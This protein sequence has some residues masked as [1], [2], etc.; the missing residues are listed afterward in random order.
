MPTDTIYWDDYPNGCGRV[1]NS[2][3]HA[4]GY[5]AS[6]NSTSGNS[7]GQDAESIGQYKTSLNYV[8]Y[9]SF[10]TFDLSSYTSGAYTVSA[11]KL[12][13]DGRSGFDSSDTDFDMWWCLGQDWGTLTGTDWND[14]SGWVSS[15][16]Y[17]PT[18]YTDTW[19]S[20]SYSNNDNEFTLNTAGKAYVEAQMEA[21]S[22]VYFVGLSH[23]DIIASQPTGAEVISFDE[24]TTLHRLQITYTDDS[25]YGNSVIGVSNPASV[26]GVAGANILNVM[27]V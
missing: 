7:G 27:G 11:G 20:A 10:L 1:Y 15:G 14:F 26:L 9:R 3:A 19:N 21:S 13:L 12:I 22:E 2:F 23:E 25:G 24:V 18:K 8:V 16:T 6:R 5:L 17:T 4:S